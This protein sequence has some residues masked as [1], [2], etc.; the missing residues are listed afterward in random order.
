MRHRVRGPALFPFVVGAGAFAFLGL[1]LLLPLAS[2][3]WVSF[4]DASGTHFTL[5]NY[6]KIITTRFYQQSLWNSLWIGALATLTTTAIG[7]P[8]AFCIARLPLPGKAALT[9]L[10]V[11]PLIL[12]SFVG[13]R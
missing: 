4:F 5:A 13:A 6:G 1:F 10:S 11:L 9:A 7:V 2:V 3:L 8:L 12:P